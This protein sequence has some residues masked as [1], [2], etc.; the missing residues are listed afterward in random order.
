M[1]HLLTFIAT[2]QDCIVT[3]LQRATSQQKTI[4]ATTKLAF[5]SPQNYINKHYIHQNLSIKGEYYSTQKFIE[6]NTSQYS[7]V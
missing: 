7:F 6:L 2:R 1:D 5:F 3:E 4:R